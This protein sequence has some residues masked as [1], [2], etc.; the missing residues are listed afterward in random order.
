[1]N[2]SQFWYLIE[3][4]KGKSIGDCQRRV[5]RLQRV[6]EQCSAEEILSFNRVLHEL[7]A[8]SYRWDLWAAAQII[9][10]WTSDDGFDYFRSWLIAQGEKAFMS[11]LRNPDSLANSRTRCRS[12]PTVKPYYRLRLERMRRRPENGCRVGPTSPPGSTTPR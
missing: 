7:L 10:R 11:A 3:K 6:L 4:A 9:N 12:E 2:R 5:V 1:M 8:R